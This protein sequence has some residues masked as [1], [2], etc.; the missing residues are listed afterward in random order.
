MTVGAPPAP[1]DTTMKNLA[2]Q[3]SSVAT[4]VLAALPIAALPAAALAAPQSVRI[5]DI[6]LLTA[7]GMQTFQRRA[8]YVA[9]GRCNGGQDLQQAAVGRKAVK[10]ELNAQGTVIRAAKLQQAPTFA[11]R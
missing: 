4:L 11:A 7:E 3:I 5:A 2:V 10:R 6:D 1:K 9:R 8:D